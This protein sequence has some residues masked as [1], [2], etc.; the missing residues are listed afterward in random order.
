VLGPDS[1]TASEDSVV[2]QFYN[3]KTIGSP[4]PMGTI[5]KVPLKDLESNPQRK[6]SIPGTQNAFVEVSLSASV[7]PS[8]EVQIPLYTH[9]GGSSKSFFNSITRTNIKQRIRLGDRGKDTEVSF[10]EVI[11]HEAS[12][13]PCPEGNS[14]THPYFYIHLNSSEGVKFKS[15][16]IRDSTTPK[17]EQK[18][19]FEIASTPGAGIQDGIRLKLRSYNP[20]GPAYDAGSIYVPLSKLKEVGTEVS[21]W[22]RADKGTVKVRIT[23]KRATKSVEDLEIKATSTLAKLNNKVLYT[24]GIVKKALAGT[25]IKCK[26]EISILMGIVAVRVAVTV[27]GDEEK[28]EEIKKIDEE[29][30]KTEKE[31]ETDSAAEPD[32]VGDEQDQDT[33]DK[34]L[35][36]RIIESGAERLIKGLKQAANKLRSLGISGAEIGVM[37]MIE[38]YNCGIQIELSA[39]IEK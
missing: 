32:Q 27:S 24:L 36:R 25:G 6:C 39:E 33:Q 3:F 31:I 1:Q 10:L 23:V 13:Y 28:P 16:I 29:I 18:F 26:V 30:N 8:K 4:D 22:Y 34:S 2:L 11:V 5:V 12:D 21:D 15:N 38:A 9:T 17:W 20:Y 14:T 19:G 7:R 37:A 35:M